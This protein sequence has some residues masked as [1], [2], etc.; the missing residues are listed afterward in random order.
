MKI[1]Y[2]IYTTMARLVPIK[3]RKHLE[4]M[5]LYAG[6]KRSVDFWVGS[7]SVLAVLLFII[8]FLSQ[9]IFFPAKEIA[10]P[11]V[12][13]LAF[14]PMYVVF[15]LLSLLAVQFLVYI[16]IYFKAADRTKRVEES[17]PDALQLMSANLR[18]GMTPFQSMKLAARKEFGPLK[19]E[20]EYATT[21]A[22]GT[23]SFAKA[24]LSMAKRIQSPLLE[25]AMK[26]FATSMKSGG[27]LAQ[28]LEDLANDIAETKALKRDLVTNTKMYSM[29]IMFMVIVGA[30]IL[31]SVSIHFIKIISDMQATTGVAEAEFGMAFLVGTISLTPGFLIKMSVAVLFVTSLLA[32]MLMGV[33]A[34][35]NEKYGLRYAPMVITA[36]LAAFAVSRHVIS[37]FFG[38]MM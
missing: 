37:S 24:L 13:P 27:R 18:A 33:I 32:S 30:P 21:K 10:K 5:L 9:L 28:L 3:Y 4:Q 35:G 16:A 1:K 19:E 22:L 12:I 29:L 31:L 38:G 15:A 2:R 36:S 26:L 17:L 8:L 25:R 6:E 23:E 14:P 7:A 11:E 34:E 20:I